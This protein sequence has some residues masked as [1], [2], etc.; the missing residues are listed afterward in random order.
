MSGPVRSVVI[1]GRDA[2]LWIAAAEDPHAVFAKAVE[3]FR[4][5]AVGLLQTEG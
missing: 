3:A 2:A 1:V 5:L 4:Q